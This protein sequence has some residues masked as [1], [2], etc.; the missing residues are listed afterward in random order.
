MLEQ[1]LNTDIRLEG[2]TT[3][4]LTMD[5]LTDVVA[6][7]NAHSMMLDGMAS[8][9]EQEIATF[10]QSPGFNLATDQL[11][12]FTSSGDLVA[13]AE[14]WDGTAQHIRYSG[15]VVV[16]PDQQGRGIGSALN[17]WLQE[18]AAHQLVLADDGHQVVMQ[19][20]VNAQD[21]AAPHV[22]A[23]QGYSIA[24]YYWRM[25]ISFNGQEPAA[26]RWPEGMRVITMAEYGQTDDHYRAVY[27]VV[28]R[29]FRDHWGFIDQP[30]ENAYA[31]W[32]HWWQNSSELDTTVWFLVMHGE[33]I[34]G[35]SLCRNTTTESEDRAWLGTLGV[36]RDYRKKG[37][38]TALLNHTFREFYSRGKKQVGLAVD[39]NSLTGAVKLYERVG[40][41]KE[42]E[43][44]LYEK[45]MR[46]GIDLS[47]HS[48]DEN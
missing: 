16:H 31:R 27:H 9:T 20:G 43:T 18:R 22:L 44:I 10:W 37:L 41:Q 46:E 34:A 12:V 48:T 3:R 13:T 35:I 14:F 33:N 36:L 45:I 15:W 39:A 1:T 42:R 8:E 40:M 28:R 5:D 2:Y 4:F 7:Y 32:I 24:R 25:L 23:K 26:P 47:K 38:A 19:T 17:L 6:L 30:F 29:A 11:G 21:K